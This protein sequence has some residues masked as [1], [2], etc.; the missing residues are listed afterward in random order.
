MIQ[1]EM[2]RVTN[3]SVFVYFPLYLPNKNFN[4]GIDFR[5]VSLTFCE[6]N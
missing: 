5:Y 1:D 4:Y 3:E 2:V 6:Q